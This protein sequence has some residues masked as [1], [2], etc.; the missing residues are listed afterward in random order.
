M[1]CDS[2]TFHGSPKPHLNA[3]LQYAMICSLILLRG[4]HQILRY[5]Q[6][7]WRRKRRAH[8][9]RNVDKSSSPQLYFL[10][11]SWD[12]RNGKSGRRGSW[13]GSFMILYGHSGVSKPTVCIVMIMFSFGVPQDSSLL[14][15]LCRQARSRSTNRFSDKFSGTVSAKFW[16]RFAFDMET[17]AS[18]SVSN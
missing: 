14:Y 18:L 9:C 11:R 15:S 17:L 5:W 8:G 7:E 12:D 1:L 16:G 6:M 4:I 13:M 3:P 2:N 10:L